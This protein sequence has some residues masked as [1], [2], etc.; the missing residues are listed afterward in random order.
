MYLRHDILDKYGRIA[1]STQECR[2][3][4]EQEMV[5]KVGGIKLETSGNLKEI[6][7]EFDVSLKKRNIGE[8]DINAGG[9]A[10]STA[11]TPKR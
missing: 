7:P 6:V 9:A 3:R 11:D 2:A 1:G 8:P 4:I 5:D 10:S